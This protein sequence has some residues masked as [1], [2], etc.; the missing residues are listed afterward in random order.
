M[1]PKTPLR[2]FSFSHRLSW[3]MDR[4]FGSLAMDSRVSSG[5]LQWFHPPPH[6]GF[7]GSWDLRGHQR[8]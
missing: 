7:P 6:A 2:T 8:L 1:S 5:L 4:G 3:H